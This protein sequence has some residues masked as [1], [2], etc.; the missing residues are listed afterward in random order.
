MCV[1]TK[2]SQKD[3]NKNITDFWFCHSFPVWGVKLGR[4]VSGA[5]FKS[6]RRQGGGCSGLS[7]RL[8]SI[9]YIKVFE[10]YNNEKIKTNLSYYYF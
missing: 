7:G 9:Q 1:G 6:K 5:I 4:Q 3:N 10:R 2:I 8:A